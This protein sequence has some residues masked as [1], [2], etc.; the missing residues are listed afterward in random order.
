MPK[1]TPPKL[2]LIKMLTYMRPEGSA[3][4]TAFNQTYLEPFM[5]LP[6]LD[7]NYIHIEGSNPTIAFMA[8]HDTVHSKSGTQR[9]HI[10]GKGTVTAKNSDCLGADC[11]TGVWLILN[12]I[13]NKIPGLYIIHAAEEEGCIG[14]RAIVDRAPVW[15][16]GIEAAISFDRRDTDSIVTHQMGMR[17]ASDEFAHSLATVLNDPYLQPDPTGSYTDSNEYAHIIPECTNLSVGYYDQHTQH[18]SQSLPF[19]Y[20]LLDRLLE[21]DWSQLDICRDPSAREYENYWSPRTPL[22]R[23]L[24]AELVGDYPDEVA[25]LLASYGITTMSLF[26]ELGL[27]PDQNDLDRMEEYA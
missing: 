22:S 21:A 7:G 23:S 5:G 9:L 11:T 25:N 2:D 27:V 24:M 10:D 20:D 3:A 6:D 4:Q 19:A 18:E 14:S 15:L 12:M 16:E 1:A 26:E 13:K 8:H 17:T